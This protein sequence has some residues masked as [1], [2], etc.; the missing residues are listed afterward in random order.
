[1]T[2]PVAKPVAKPVVKLV[3]GHPVIACYLQVNLV[4][5]IWLDIRWRMLMLWLCLLIRC[6]KLV[7]RCE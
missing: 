6:N 5:V 4:F 7:W 2:E 3:S 1:M